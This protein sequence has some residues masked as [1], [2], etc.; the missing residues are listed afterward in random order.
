MKKICIGIIV[1]LRLFSFASDAVIPEAGFLPDSAKISV[2]SGITGIVTLSIPEISLSNHEQDSFFDAFFYRHKQF[3]FGR[4][5]NR[6]YFNFYDGKRWTAYIDSDA[7]F[8]LE[9]GRIYQLAFTMKPHQIRSHG[10]LWTDIVLYADGHETGRARIVDRI[11]ASG[12]APIQFAQADGFGNGWNCNG[13]FYNMKL[14]NRALDAEAVAE[15][16]AKE[17]HIHFK[18]VG[19]PEISDAIRKKID[20][21][22]KQHDFRARKKD[23]SFINAVISALQSYAQIHDEAAFLKI[24]SSLEKSFDAEKRTISPALHALVS[25]QTVLI[26]SPADNRILTWYDLAHDENLLQTGNN[27][28]FQ[29]KY[30]R[31]GRSQTI[32][33]KSSQVTQK[34]VAKPH[35]TDH[36]WHWTTRYQHNDMTAVLHYSYAEDSLRYHLNIEAAPGIRLHEVTFPYVKLAPRNEGNLLIPCMSGAVKRNTSANRFTYSGYYPSGNATMQFGAYYS[37]QGGV[38][39]AA[40]DG[41]A[42]AKSFLFRASQHGV[43]IACSWPAAYQPETDKPSLFAPQCDAVLTAFTGDWYEAG[44]LYKDF[45]KRSAVWYQTAEPVTAYPDWFRKNTL[46]LVLHHRSNSAEKLA[47]LREYFEL[48]FAV[49]YYNWFGKFDRDYPHHHANPQ[50]YLWMQNIKKMGINIIPYT[51]GRLWELL[52]R[53]DN[54]YRYTACGKPDAV[55][56]PDGNVQTEKYNGVS[57]AVMCPACKNWQN[58]LKSLARRVLGY[59]GDGM[60]M[61]QIGAARPRLCFDHSHPHLPNDPD[62]WYMNGYRKLLLDLHELYPNAIWTTEDNAEPYV[63]LM[64]GL[65]SWRW[66]VD[67]NVPLFNMLYSGKTEMTGRAFGGDTP[68]TRKVKIY[69]QLL[70]GEQ[71]GWGGVDF[72]TQK[73]QAD[74]RLTVKRAMHLR[75]GLLDYF[76]QGTL[77][78]SP[79]IDKVNYRNLKWG[80]FAD[81]IVSTPDIVSTMWKKQDI[82]VI[83]MVNQSEKERTFQLH[84]SPDESWTFMSVDPAAQCRS[85]DHEFSIRMPPDNVAL[86]LSGRGEKFA[87]ESSRLKQLFQKISQF[88]KR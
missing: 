45:L 14:F 67:G 35:M 39:F 85:G 36:T 21:F 44:L 30:Y 46:W 62:S 61:D 34:A 23:K 72:I 69:Q 38:Y 53:R 48:P 51:N 58:E 75:L 19:Q 88:E 63:G 54:D 7:D 43:E 40:E 55:K 20:S 68:L 25:K 74:F 49:H 64:H 31:Q 5:G 27:A 79:G 29:T 84:C 8:T 86:I 26:L 41:R 80:N 73:D 82:Q 66:M 3:I 17:K 18:P 50:H 33:G 81:Q 2:E 9:A 87:S 76:Q 15:I 70:Q 6:L 56:L 4:R 71:L 32:S 77:M 59:G 83:M 52:D 65:L 28:W 12:N 78:K 22:K 13:S 57:F 1:L 47:W 11:P 10:E 24:L 37:R 60:Y 42:R 16:A